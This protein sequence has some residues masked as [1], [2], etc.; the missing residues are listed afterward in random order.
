[1]KYHLG[2]GEA[3]L[4]G[5]CNVDFPPENRTVQKQTRVDLE[6]DLLVMPYKPCEEIRSSHVFEHFTYVESLVLLCRWSLALIPG[7]L[8]WITVPDVQAIV[9]YGL[10]TG[11][12]ARTMRFLYGSH[13]APWAVHRN[14]WTEGLLWQVMEKLGYDLVSSHM[15]GN[16]GNCSLSMCFTKRRE[17]NAVELYAIANSMLPW[18]LNNGNETALLEW[19]RGQLAEALK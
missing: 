19:W 3:Y 8:L 2:C 15:T 17:I 11:D 9:K 7:G 1:M 6:A 5:Y 12:W 16:R 13:E 10:A 4:D 18:Y 14:G